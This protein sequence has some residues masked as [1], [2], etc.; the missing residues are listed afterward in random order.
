MSDQELICPEC[1]E[2][3]PD[4]DRVKAA[5]SAQEPKV[6]WWTPDIGFDD[7]IEKYDTECGTGFIPP[8]GDLKDHYVHCPRCGG[9]IKIKES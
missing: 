1:G 7:E 3:R 6:C 8:D 4:D 2:P 9:V 5:L